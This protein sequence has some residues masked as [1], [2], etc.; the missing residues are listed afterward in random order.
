MSSYVKMQKLVIPTLWILWILSYVIYIKYLVQCLAVTKYSINIIIIVCDSDISKCF[1]MHLVMMKRCFYT[2]KF[3]TFHIAGILSSS[4]RMKSCLNE[5]RLSFFSG[6]NYNKLNVFV[7]TW[8]GETAAL[9]SWRG[10]LLVSGGDLEHAGAGESKD[11]GFHP[12][13]AT[14][15]WLIEASFSATHC[16]S[17][18]IAGTETI[19]C[20]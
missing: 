9:L 14:T 17:C 12:C 20:W 3:I 16:I 15:E 7:C 8:N 11:H 10:K 5:V 18:L 13:F 2:G 6:N 19:F 1:L 4:W